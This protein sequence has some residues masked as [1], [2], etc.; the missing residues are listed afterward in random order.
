MFMK[1][2]MP[3]GVDLAIFATWAVLCATIVASVTLTPGLLVLMM[4]PM[5]FIAMVLGALRNGKL[6]AAPAKAAPVVATATV[7]QAA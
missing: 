6:D 3:K 2:V 1:Y 5:L 7:E 4:A